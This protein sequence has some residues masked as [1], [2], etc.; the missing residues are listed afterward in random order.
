[1][2]PGG[3]VC[4]CGYATPAVGRPQPV[5]PI[6]VGPRD[7]PRSSGR[8]PSR[9]TGGS[10][11]SKVATVEAIPVSYPEPNDYNALRH[12]CLVK[13]TTTTAALAGGKPFTSFPTPH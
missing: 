11:V 5:I 7:T 9:P 10:P 1:M 8:P 3:N 12:L 4:G 13:I 2:P 6:A